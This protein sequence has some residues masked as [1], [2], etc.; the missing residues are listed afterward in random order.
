MKVRQA[1][2]RDVVT[3]APDASILEAGELMLRHNVSG[4]PVVNAA[5][6]LVGIVT[7]RDFLRPGREGED[8]RRPRW[9]EVLAGGPTGPDLLARGRERK[10]SDVMTPAPL[11]VTEETPL[12]EAVHLMESRDVKRLPVVR[13]TR[14]VGIVARADMLRALIKSLRRSAAAAKGDEAQR[15]RLTALERDSWLHRTRS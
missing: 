8:K 1:M 13:G 2:T 7:E 14:V 15:A 9:F 5:G 10:V 12:E 3:V 4:L 11:T 6:D